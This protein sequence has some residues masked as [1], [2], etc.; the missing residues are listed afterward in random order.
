MWSPESGGAAMQRATLCL[1]L[2]LLLIFGCQRP[3]EAE[4]DDVDANEPPVIREILCA[5]VSQDGRQILTAETGETWGGARHARFLTLWDA[6]GGAKK[7]I[8]SV[9]LAEQDEMEKTCF[10]A[11]AFDSGGRWV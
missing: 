10:H 9:S 5:D 8:W 7:E 2:G 4:R 1:F 6:S 11:V 3:R